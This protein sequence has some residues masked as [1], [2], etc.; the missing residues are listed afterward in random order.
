MA[1]IAMTGGLVGEVL[2][3]IEARNDPEGLM[4][5]GITG[6]MWLLM[7]FGLR[8]LYV[9]AKD[10]TLITDGKSH[11]LLLNRR[12][13]ILMGVRELGSSLVVVSSGFSVAGY[14]DT[15]YISPRHLGYALLERLRA[16]KTG[17]PSH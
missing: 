16:G 6:A 12:V 17:G 13:A 11:V 15:V 14:E 3:L 9:R 2:G 8:A 7:V 10:V 1:V 5:F 4:V